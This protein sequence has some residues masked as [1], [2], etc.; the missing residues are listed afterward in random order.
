MTLVR[1]RGFQNP[2]A[3]GL[4]LPN[5]NVGGISE[6]FNQWGNSG[7]VHENFNWHDVLTWQ[8]GKHTITTGV[9]IDR[10]HDDDNFTN[11]LIRPSFY[12]GNLLDFAQ[13]YPFSQS[14]PIVNVQTG[15]LA[16][17]L[18][19]KIRWLYEGLHSCRMIGN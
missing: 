2:P 10:H 17:N 11:G 4:E 6:G 18:Y 16:N 1:A 15:S 3:N 14:G 9:D 7:W 5:V 8:H 12:F 19:E 13:S